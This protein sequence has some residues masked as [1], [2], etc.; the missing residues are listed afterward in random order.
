MNKRQRGFTILEIMICLAIIA[1]TVPSLSMALDTVMKTPHRDSAN[2]E[3]SYD[4]SNA[5]EWITTDANQAE[6]PTT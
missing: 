5:T 2:L 3:A 1:I 4:V 6:S